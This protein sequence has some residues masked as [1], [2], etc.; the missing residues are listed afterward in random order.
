MTDLNA[1]SLF[2][3]PSTP[4]P[5][6]PGTQSPVSDA[7]ADF[8]PSDL[9]DEITQTILTYVVMDT[10][11][12]HAATL[13]I[14]M[15]WFIDQIDVAPLALIT[16]PEKACG[17]SQLLTIFSYLVAHPLSVANST[18]SFIFRVIECSQPTILIDEADTFL[19][20]AGELKGIINAGHTRANAFVGRTEATPS[21]ALA[22]KLFSVWCAKAF[23][24]IGI[25]KHLPDA[26]ISR[27]IVITLRRKMSHE[28]VERLRHANRSKFTPLADK[29]AAFAK[30]FSSRIRSARPALPDALSDR[31]QDNWEPLLAIAE[32]AGPKWIAHA[33]AAALKISKSGE[34][35]VSIGNELLADIQYAFDKKQQPKISTA[36]LIGELASDDE[37]PWATYNRGKSISPRQ[38]SRLLEPYGI[39]PKTVRLGAFD[40]PKGYDREQFIDAFARYLA[41]ADA[42]AEEPTDKVI[43]PSSST[44]LPI[45]MSEE[46][47]L[48]ISKP[49]SIDIDPETAF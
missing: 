30:A 8:S 36:D 39:R 31:A 24:G 20:D 21:G 43:P 35:S 32:I 25:E 28:H 13:W 15:T 7:L 1:P 17:K 41:T 45:T 23:A 14:A 49:P 22:P 46:S 3:K 44:L 16:A 10:E 38:L 37:K 12:A 11:Q 48:G 6:S 40:T 4:R 26:T 42:D 2:P 9:L 34:K 19:R 27:S 29:L 47:A 33:T 5:E 18:A